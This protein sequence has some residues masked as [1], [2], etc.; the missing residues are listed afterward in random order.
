MNS[1][2]EL[3]HSAASSTPPS[4]GFLRDGAGIVVSVICRDRNLCR[5]ERA[6]TWPLTELPEDGW[7]LSPVLDRFPAPCDSM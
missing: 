7:R 5:F 1:T 3:E 2:S 6:A 4:W